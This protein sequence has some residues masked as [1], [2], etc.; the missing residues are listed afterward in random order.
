MD[1]VRKTVLAYSSVCSSGFSARCCSEVETLEILLLLV[2][3]AQMFQLAQS[4]CALGGSSTCSPLKRLIS[5]AF[6]D[7]HAVDA[8]SHLEDISAWV[9]DWSR[10]PVVELTSSVAS[11]YWGSKSDAFFLNVI[12]TPRRTISLLPA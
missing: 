12:S 10:H 9:V 3:L 8:P 11:L 6:A 4:L 7:L 1:Q 5:C 2:P